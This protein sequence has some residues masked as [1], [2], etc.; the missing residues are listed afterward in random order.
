[1]NLN[2]W[3]ALGL[4]ALGLIVSA[5][6]GARFPPAPTE[7]EAETAI[8]SAW[9]KDVS[10]ASTRMFP[11]AVTTLPPSIA[12]SVMLAI[13]FVASAPTPAPDIEN[14]ALADRVNPIAAAS[15]S[16]LAP[17]EASTVTVPSA[18]TWESSILAVVTPPIEFS[19]LQKSVRGSPEPRRPHRVKT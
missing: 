12:A 19:V 5:C 1:M 8:N 18:S 7:I 9:M 15:A 11:P 2:R 17:E 3:S 13:P 16:M 4:V 14:P 10:E 6:G